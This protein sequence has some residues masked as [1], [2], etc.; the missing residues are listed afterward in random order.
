MN[1]AGKKKEWGNSRDTDMEYVSRGFEGIERCEVPVVV[2]PVQHMGCR[3]MDLEEPF[4]AEGIGQAES[5]GVG[6]VGLSAPSD[7]EVELERV[8]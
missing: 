6:T 5:L 8:G 4:A 3:L 2:L 1:F 7:S